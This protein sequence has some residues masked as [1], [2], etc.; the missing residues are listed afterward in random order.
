MLTYIVYLYT[1]SWIQIVIHLLK[2][3]L[4]KKKKKKKK[5]KINTGLEFDILKTSTVVFLPVDYINFY[6]IFCLLKSK[7]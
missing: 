1:V 3:Y 2:L 7:F 6:N 5:K 4:K